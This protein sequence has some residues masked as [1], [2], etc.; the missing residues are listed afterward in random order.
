MF[1]KL[2][3]FQVILTFLLSRYTELCTSFQ[4][5]HPVDFFKFHNSLAHK[6]LTCMQG[7]SSIQGRH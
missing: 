4:Q 1:A 2:K 3:I 7:Y 6:M 5:I